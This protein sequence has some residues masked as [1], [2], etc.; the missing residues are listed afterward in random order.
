MI[1]VSSDWHGYPLDKIKDLLQKANFGPEDFLFVLGD[2]IDRGKNGIELLKFLMYSSNAELILGNH[3]AMLLSN[4]WLFDEITDISLC[5]FNSKKIDLLQVWKSNGAE[6]TISGLSKESPE[7]REDILEYLRDCP[8]YDS[9]SVNGK[10]FFL[11]HAG[12][13]N[14]RQDKRI[15]EYTE[16]ELLWTRPYLTTHYSSDFTVILGH[17]PTVYYGDKYKGKILENSTWINIDTGAACGSAPCLL[18]LDDMK[19][20]YT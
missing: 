19:V 14:Y 1:Y 15:D 7:A 4:S 16:D 17:T 5:A 9:V 13:G 12:L 2:V 20:F 18:R 6:P 3:E 8:I 10:D 11:V